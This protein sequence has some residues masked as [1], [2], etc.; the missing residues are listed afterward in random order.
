MAVQFLISE[1]NFK[2]QPT[3]RTTDMSATKR[4]A[5]M[6]GGKG[7]QPKC[8]D[9]GAEICRGYIKRCWRSKEHHLHIAAE[10]ETAELD[11]KEIMAAKFIVLALAACAV[12]EASY[13]YGGNRGYGGYG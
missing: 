9:A 2:S 11:S 7:I 10:T 3:V 1:T 5:S 12:A 6:R 13:G 4:H 8:Q